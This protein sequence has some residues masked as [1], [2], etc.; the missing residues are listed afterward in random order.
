MIAAEALIPNIT[1][2]KIFFG[3]AGMSSL[4]SFKI[5]PISKEIVKKEIMAVVLCIN[6]IPHTINICNSIVTT[7]DIHFITDAKL[8]E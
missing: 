3:R 7:R 4:D 8:L 5:T 1:P 6:P 2:D